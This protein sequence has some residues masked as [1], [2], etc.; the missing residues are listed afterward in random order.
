MKKFYLTALTMLV[1]WLTFVGV[2]VYPTYAQYAF[3][4]DSTTRFAFDRT[5]NDDISGYTGDTLFLIRYDGDDESGTVDLVTGNLA[6]Y[7]G[8]LAAETIDAQIE[9]IADTYAAACGVATGI[10]LGVAGAC[11]TYGEVADIVNAS[12]DWRMIL[13]ESF[14][15][16]TWEA[17]GAEMTDPGDVQA[18][19]RVGLEV[20]S[21]TSDNTYITSTAYPHYDRTVYDDIRP[22]AGTWQTGGAGTG[23]FRQSELMDGYRAWVIYIQYRSSDGDNNDAIITF[24]SEELDGDYTETALGTIAVGTDDTWVYVDENTVGSIVPIAAN[25]GE[26]MKVRMASANMDTGD[27]DLLVVYAFERVPDN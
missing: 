11:D 21:D 14:R 27:N 9:T 26:L 8:V 17:A 13:L 25:P 1:V 24:Y 3:L 10:D 6:L 7:D 15:S 22:F 12:D 18:K 23:E 2:K 16:D 5:T 4:F 20:T 19:L